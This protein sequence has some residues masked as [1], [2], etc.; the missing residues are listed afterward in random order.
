MKRF[1]WA[2][3]GVLALTGLDQWT[4][5]LALAH[6]QGQPNI[7]VWDGVFELQF[8]TNRGAAFGI[9]QNQRWIF[10]VMT[11]AIMAALLYFFVKLPRTKHFLPLSIL[12][13]VL[14]AGALGNMIDRVRLGYVIDFLYFKLI[15]FPTFNVAD[16]YVTV[17]TILAAIL[18]VFYYKDEDWNLLKKKER[19]VTEESGEQESHKEN[20]E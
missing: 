8:I 16:C 10:L 13:V 9:F 14:E 12:C 17:G 20:A 3:L 15:D 2:I 6:L 18:L 11:V 1:L 4:K 5:Y 19:G 7:V